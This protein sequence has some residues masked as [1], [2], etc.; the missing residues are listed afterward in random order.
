MH[1]GSERIVGFFANLLALRTARQGCATFAALVERERDTVADALRHQAV[2]FDQVV[3]QVGVA[4][5]AARSPLFQVNF[6][7]QDTKGAVP[8]AAEPVTPAGMPA[9]TVRDDLYRYAQFDL[10]LFAELTS[11]G[12]RCCTVFRTDLF[13]AADIERLS[14]TYAQY[15]D[16]LT[17]QPDAPFGTLA[18]ATRPRATLRGWQ[19]RP[20]GSRCPTRSAR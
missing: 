17:A 13:E 9:M 8:G 15:L 20:L 3:E 7:L 6:V 10:T 4:R 2:S 5:D 12:V 14:R 11:D 18:R 1:P 16:A 19:S